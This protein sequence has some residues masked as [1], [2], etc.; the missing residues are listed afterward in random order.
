MGSIIKK[1]ITS[2]SV[3]SRQYNMIGKDGHKET[4]EEKQQLKTPKAK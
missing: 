1:A 2:S 4:K 3:I